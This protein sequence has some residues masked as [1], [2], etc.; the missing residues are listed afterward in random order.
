MGRVMILHRS[1]Q[2]V[3]IKTHGGLALSVVGTLPLYLLL[4]VPWELPTKVKPSSEVSILKT[5]SG[6]CE[7]DRE[8]RLST[9]SAFNGIP[10][11]RCDKVSLPITKP[12]YPYCAVFTLLTSSKLVVSPLG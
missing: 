7:K 9:L 6:S 4:A 10:K 1:G 2:V 5:C 8:Q 3:K 12:L 11:T